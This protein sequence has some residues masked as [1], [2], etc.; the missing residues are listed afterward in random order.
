MTT[1]FRKVFTVMLN[2]AKENN[3]KQEDM[4]TTLLCISDMEFNEAGGNSTNFEAIKQDYKESGYE[5]PK[6]V[7][8][9]VNGRPGNCPITKGDRAILVS[10]ASPSVI[11]AV[12]SGGTDPI[13][14]MEDTINSKRYGIFDNIVKEFI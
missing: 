3:V 2:K 12:L 10:G 7:F 5:F 4:P 8:W 11:K 13:K 6:L 9:N 1:D 14:V